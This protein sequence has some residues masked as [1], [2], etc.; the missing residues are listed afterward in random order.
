MKRARR[1]EERIGE[2]EREREQEEAEEEQI[3]EDVENEIKRRKLYDAN[4]FLL[5]E[6]KIEQTDE[7]F[8]IR[9]PTKPRKSDK[10]QPLI[11]DAIGS[12]KKDRPQIVSRSTLSAQMKHKRPLED[13]Q[14]SRSVSPPPNQPVN[15]LLYICVYFEQRIM[16]Q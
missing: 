4:F 7:Y 16:Y 3:R 12:G 2:A 8:V 10:D 14:P 11:T 9:G 5:N 13:N 6:N 1:D 15:Q